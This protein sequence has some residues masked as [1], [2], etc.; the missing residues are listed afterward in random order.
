MDALHT[1][2]QDLDISMDAGFTCIPL[3]MLGRMWIPIRYM[4]LSKG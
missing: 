4:L 2:M 3:Y 1:G